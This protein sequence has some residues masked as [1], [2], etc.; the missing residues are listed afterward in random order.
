MS[1]DSEAQSALTPSDAA[2]AVPVIRLQRGSSWWDLGLG[3]LWHYRELLW[4]LTARDIKARYRQMALGP[5]WILIQPVIDMVVYVLIFQKLANIGTDGA[6][7]PLFLFAAIL[8]WNYFAT[9][10]NGGVGSLIGAMP[11]IS[12]V[13]FPRLAIPISTVLSGLVD[14]LPRFIILAVMVGVY[15]ARGEAAPPG[16]AILMLPVYVLLAAATSL[17]VGLWGATLA[18]KYRD[19]RFVVRTAVDF[20]K[21]ATPLVYPLSLIARKIPALVP[22]YKMNPMY[23]VLAGFR[24]SVYGGGNDP[25]HFDIYFVI[26]SAVVVVLLVAGTVVFRR[27][28]R[29]IVDLL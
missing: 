6:P 29:T 17:A 16:P 18:V 12:K 19:L 22:V 26:S 13:Y 2:S 28:E 9:A 21:Y 5:L 25:V 3:E 11:M 23:W 20:W 4:F 24:T 27:T 8:P 1:V 10:A 7:G 14:L 15:V